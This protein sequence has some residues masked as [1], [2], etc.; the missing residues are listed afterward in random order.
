MNIKLQT[1]LK[2]RIIKRV[3]SY[4]SIYTFNDLSN[5]T[6]EEL[7]YIQN[8]TLVRLIIKV[9]FKNRKEYKTN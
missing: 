1:S 8:E 2:N 3:L 5:K 6:I 9:R 7:N 4:T